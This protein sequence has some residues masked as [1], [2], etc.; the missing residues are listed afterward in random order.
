MPNSRWI[1]DAGA[2]TYAWLT[3]Q[4]PWRN[5]C[6]T[7]VDHFPQGVDKLRILDLGIGPG[8]SGISILDRLPEA[9]LVGLDFSRRMLG[10]AQ[11][12]ITQSEKRIQLVHAD[13][14]SLPFGDGSFDVV[15]GH[16]FLYIVPDRSRVVAEVARVLASGGRSVFLEPN[17]HPHPLAWLRL[18]GSARFL[19]SMAAWRTFSARKGRFTR[20]SLRALLARHLQNVQVVETLEGLGLIATGNAA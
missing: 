14:A 2:E 19:F 15:T 1:F 8:V 13:A 3:W 11:R 20:S 17:E 16:S 5:H 4:N 12:Y 6:R 7:L 9:E 10:V 18:K